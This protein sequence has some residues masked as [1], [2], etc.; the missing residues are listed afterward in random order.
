MKRK[1]ERDN[2]HVARREGVGRFSY[3]LNPQL[4]LIILGPPNLLILSFNI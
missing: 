1:R 4:L 3:S 2:G